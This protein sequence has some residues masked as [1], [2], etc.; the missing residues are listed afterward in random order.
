MKKS[1]SLGL[2]LY[3]KSKLEPNALIIGI[4]VE[5]FLPFVS[6]VISSSSVGVKS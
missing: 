3:Q 4:R 2:E 1:E 5:H 6:K